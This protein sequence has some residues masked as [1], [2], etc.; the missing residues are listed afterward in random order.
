MDAM[1]LE[2]GWSWVAG[3]AFSCLLATSR[4]DSNRSMWLG[5]GETEFKARLLALPGGVSA[6][7]SPV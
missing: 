4:Y 5:C 3:T 2:P 1:E 7:S 6:R